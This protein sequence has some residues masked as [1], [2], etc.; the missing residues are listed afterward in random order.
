[1]LSIQDKKRSQVSL[2]GLAAGSGRP[3]V[4]TDSPGCRD[5]VQDGLNG[6]LVPPKNV[7]ALVQALERLI[8]NMG[9][10]LSMGL[11]GRERAAREFSMATVND[12]TLNLYREL[13]LESSQ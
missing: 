2:S 1:M 12:Q 8:A 3:I 7:E 6:L 4:T 10:R 13:W 9:L 11:A 5:V